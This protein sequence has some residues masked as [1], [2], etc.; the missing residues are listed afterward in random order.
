VLPFPSLHLG[1]EK[2]RLGD[3]GGKDEGGE[4]KE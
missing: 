2:G 4:W 1:K 3:L